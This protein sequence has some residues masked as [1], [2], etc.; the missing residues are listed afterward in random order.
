ME[1]F[2]KKHSFFVCFFI[3]RKNILGG[4]NRFNYPQIKKTEALS[5]E[6][7]LLRILFSFFSL[8]VSQIYSSPFGALPPKNQRASK[9]K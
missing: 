4:A 3:L 7:P 9:G 5:C 2:V 8:R 6:A 1:C